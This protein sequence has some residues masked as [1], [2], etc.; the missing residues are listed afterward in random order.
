MTVTRCDGRDITGVRD[1]PICVLCGWRRRSRGWV[2]IGVFCTPWAGIEFF[3]LVLCRTMVVM[4]SRIEA[5]IYDGLDVL[6]DCHRVGPW[7]HCGAG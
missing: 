3:G 2:H 1:P 5:V 6:R 4:G 7:W